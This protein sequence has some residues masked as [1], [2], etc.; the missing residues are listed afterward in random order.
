MAG[1]FGPFVLLGEP[2]T[3]L[4]EEVG[5]D[6]I[7]NDA[8]GV[9]NKQVTLMVPFTRSVMETAMAL[10]AEHDMVLVEHEIGV[11]AL[12]N[13]PAAASIADISIAAGVETTT[14][15]EMK[16]WKYQGRVRP[17]DLDRVRDTKSLPP[18]L[19]IVVPVTDFN[20]YKPVEGYCKGRFLMRYHKSRL[21]ELLT[22]MHAGEMEVAEMEGSAAPRSIPAFHPQ[23]AR[24]M[25]FGG[26]PGGTKGC[27]GGVRVVLIDNLMAK[28]EDGENFFPFDIPFE[29]TCPICKT[30]GEGPVAAADRAAT[31]ALSAEASSS[32]SSSPSSSS[33]SSSSPSSTITDDEAAKKAA[34]KAKEA[35][36]KKAQK[37][38]KKE[39]K[40][41]GASSE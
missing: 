2:E 16:H 26:C 15:R 8:D 10:D 3:L 29:W 17:F 32:P 24:M 6:K 31:D 39:R 33:S 9:F 1:E 36:R 35:A 27:C 13:D 34:K 38:A 40:A 30:S 25:T 37:K 7:N 41:E 5:P 20:E 12:K 18:M 22:H 21:S 11:M 19:D 14:I 28:D 23:E 4:H